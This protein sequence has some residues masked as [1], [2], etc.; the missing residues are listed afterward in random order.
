MRSLFGSVLGL[1][2]VWLSYTL[3]RQ[4][5]EA[6]SAEVVDPSRVI[7]VFGEIVVVAVAFAIVILTTFLPAVAEW[8]GNLVF[9]PNEQI[10]KS[11]HT[12]ALAAY[13]RGEYEQAVNEY[14]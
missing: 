3:F 5:P 13:A 7:V 12:A 9:N 2:L 14:K 1:A 10:E 8:M 6:Y 4:A 11:P